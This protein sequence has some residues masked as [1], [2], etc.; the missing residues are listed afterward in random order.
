MIKLLSG[1]A[2]KKSCMP[3]WLRFM[4][5]ADEMGTFTFWVEGGRGVGG[6]DNVL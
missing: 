1:L 2:P 3:I 6:G 5:V 4:V